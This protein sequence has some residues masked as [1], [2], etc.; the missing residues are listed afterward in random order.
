[1]DD[2][3]K[4]MEGVDEKGKWIK[5]YLEPNFRTSTSFKKLKP[6][7]NNFFY[8]RDSKRTKVKLPPK[9]NK[10]VSSVIK[11]HDDYMYKVQSLSIKDPIFDYYRKKKEGIDPS[12]VNFGKGVIP[13]IQK[14][15]FYEHPEYKY[16]EKNISLDFN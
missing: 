3:N 6:K 8:Y 11:F 5:I 1:M 2:H 12:I 7:W 10:T 4:N 15:K 9:K 13:R 16:E 14:K